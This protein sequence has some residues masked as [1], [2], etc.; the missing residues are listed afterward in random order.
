MLAAGVAIPLAYVGLMGIRELWNASR[1]QLDE[2]IRQHAQLTAAAFEQWIE[3]QR[4]PLATLAAHQPAES[5]A[6]P[7]FLRT[8]KLTASTRPH[9]LG[10]QV[11]DP[12]GITLASEPRNA[13]V[14]SPELAV[15]LLKEAA[16][17]DW[18]I[19]TDWS[20]GIGDG[21]LLLYT[22]LHSGG[23]LVAQLD[24]AATNSSFLRRVNLSDQAVFSL[25][26]PQKRII[27]YRVS[28]EDTYLGKD[29]SGSAFFEALG[30]QSAA[31]V[32]LTSPMDGKR[33][34]YGLARAGQTGCVAMVGMPSSSLYAPAR[35][36][37]RR[38]IM[39]TVAGLLLAVLAA[40]FMARSIARPVRQL[41]VAA[42]RF[43]SGDPSVR[44][45]FRSSGELEELRSSF[46]SMAARI[47]EREARLSELDRLKSDFVSGV[48]HEMRTPLTTIKALTR[49]L[50]RGDP[51]DAERT[52]FLKTIMAECDRQIDLVLN[53]LDLSR[54][55]AGTFN[56]TLS[57]VDVVGVINSCIETERYNAEARHHQLSVELP[58]E[59][60]SVLADKAALR[61]VVCGLLQ[62]AIKYTPDGGRIN[63]TA[64]AD[65]EQIKI[66]IR[67]NGPGILEQDLPKIFEKFY[68][69]RLGAASVGNRGVNAIVDLAEAPGVG[70]G[71]YLAR[72]IIEEIGGHITV[73]STVGLGT[74]FTIAVPAWKNSVSDRGEQS[75]QA[76]EGFHG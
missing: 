19:L 20:R 30:N 27:L 68:R 61:R 37:L 52:E 23:A 53:L 34:V 38:Y 2:S 66:V 26:G 17:Q 62:N 13:P 45:T 59:L 40:L 9:W 75:E 54:I 73:E 28:T 3:A 56:I 6:N 44:A 60:P 71:L 7:D 70:L 11:L 41:T 67:D 25:F 65:E 33:R 32:E 22:P 18:T 5:I 50:L 72:T 55:E 47:A 35:E 4:E 31:V 1:N 15:R 39:L 46:N 64:T 43:G 69:G 42:R 36:Q 49:V 29:L 63:V 10:I 16:S 8:L 51:S 57:S 58:A 24:I 48:S 12:N 76:Q 21:L 74:R 14:L